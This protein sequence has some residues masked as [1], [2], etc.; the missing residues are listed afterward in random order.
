MKKILIINGP[1]LNMTG[2]REP[3]IY[4]S[5][6]LSDINGLIKEKA[7]ELG[8]A[9]E[10]YQSNCEGSII[11]RIHQAYNEQDGIIINPGAYSHYSL[12]I[13][14]AL[15]AVNIRTI[16]VH[17][18]NVFKRESVRTEMVTATAADVVI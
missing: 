2:I 15:R 10:F 17:I 18:S 14:D 12:A 7:D 1:N 6:T 16:E 3:E 13:A 5:K 8:V 9:V 4:G 11:D